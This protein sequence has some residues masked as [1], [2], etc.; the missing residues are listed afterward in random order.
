MKTVEEII[1]YLEMELVDAYES[2]DMTKG[3]DKQ[4]SLFFQLKAAAILAIL[5]DIK[6]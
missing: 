2:Y 6:K 5:E 4:Q 1:A 3:W